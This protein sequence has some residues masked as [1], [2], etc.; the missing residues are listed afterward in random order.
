MFLSKSFKD[1][2]FLVTMVKQLTP[3][4]MTYNEFFYVIKTIV[5]YLV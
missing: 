5:P 2:Y 1:D 3:N 4:W